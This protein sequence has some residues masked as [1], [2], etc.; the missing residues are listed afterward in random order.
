MQLSRRATAHSSC[1]MSTSCRSSAREQQLVTKADWKLAGS[2][3]RRVASAHRVLAS[4]CDLKWGRSWVAAAQKLSVHL[5][6]GRH[7][8]RPTAASGQ[9]VLDAD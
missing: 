6:G 9:M 4:S 3:T 1:E 5:R 2:E 8:R 7:L